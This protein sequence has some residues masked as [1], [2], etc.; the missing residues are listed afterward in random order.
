MYSI[1]NRICMLIVFKVYLNKLKKVD[2]SL[3][4]QEYFVT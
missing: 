2:L 1:K 4:W 3:I